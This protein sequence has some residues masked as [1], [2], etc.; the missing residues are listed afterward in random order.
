MRKYNVQTYSGPAGLTFED[1]F[2]DGSD[3]GLEKARRLQVRRWRALRRELKG[4]RWPPRTAEKH[5]AQHQLHA[6][7]RRVRLM[8]AG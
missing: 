4:G 2:E 3:Q 7:G 6:D 5:H 8:K 1:F